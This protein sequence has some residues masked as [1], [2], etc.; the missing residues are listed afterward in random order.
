MGELMF[1]LR[2]A[3]AVFALAATGWSAEKAKPSTP[4]AKKSALNRAALEAYVRHL[5]VWGPQIQVTVDEPKPSQLPGFLE[6]GVHAT[7][8]NARQDEKFYVSQDGQKIVRGQVF[9]VNLNPFKPELDKLKTEFQP[10]F[11]TPGAP[12]VL[13]IFSDF[14]CP[15]CREEAKMLRENVVATYPKQVRVYFKDLPLEQIHN[16]AKPAALAGR[17]V[18]RQNAGM[19]WRYHDWVFEAQDKLTAE[20]FRDKV[21]E[22]A[23]Q[24]DLDSLQLR[25]CLDTKAT[26][27]EVEKSV[28]EARELRVMSTPTL[29]V[30]GRRIPARIGWPELK[31][32]IDFEIEYQKTAKNAGEDCGCEVKLPTPLN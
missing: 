11:G 7:A 25:Q 26:L 23:N 30:N 3:I 4:A 13:V 20:N 2:I 18:F 32:V 21:M 8:G 16:W 1:R 15:Y 5:F 29:F 27:A 9:D 12:V 28:A 31:Q 17:C 6:V 24:N 10:S 14:Q 22:F 19:F